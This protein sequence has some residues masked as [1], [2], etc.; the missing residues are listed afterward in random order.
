MKQF[1]FRENWYIC[2]AEFWSEVEPCLLILDP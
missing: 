1:D 2:Q